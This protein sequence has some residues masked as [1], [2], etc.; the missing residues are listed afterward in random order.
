MGTLGPQRKAPKKKRKALKKLKK[1]TAKSLR[2]PSMTLK[3]LIADDSATIQKIVALA[4]SCEDAV[5]E[6]VSNGDAAL[7]L[8]RS[9]K[10]DVVL[11]DIFMPG[12]SGYEIC[13]HI[14]E[15]TELANIPVVL[16]SGTFEPFDEMEASRVKCDGHLTKPFD[17]SELIK[18][19]QSL[20]EKRMTTQK[21]ETS[22]ETPVMDMQTK[23]VSMPE[24][25]R[26][27]L[28]GLV[29]P[30]VWD[31]YLSSNRILDLFDSE[32]LNAAQRA[33][34]ASEHFPEIP[35]ATNAL[36]AKRSASPDVLLSED[37]LKRIVDRVMQRM[38]AEI[39]REVAWEVVPELSE[40]IIRR[41][42][43]EQNKP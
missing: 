39:I 16:L 11:A 32:I 4:F 34:P 8:I 14:K 22:V 23:A 35:A 1:G 5:V 13:E 3:L 18:T 36:D 24:L 38:S 20:A 17:T 21:S 25:H 10:P 7:D 42:I 31:S 19:V 29:S 12:C 2:E 40:S 9:F 27:G 43:E 28:R 6:S 26:P 41:T 37:T 33:R 30:P 15:D